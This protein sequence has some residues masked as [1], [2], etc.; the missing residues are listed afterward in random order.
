[1]SQ[2]RPLFIGMD[3]HQET[4]AVAYGAQDPGAAG[5]SLGP[6]GTRQ[7]ASDHLV[8]KRPAQATPL[9]LVYAAGPCGDWR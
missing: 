4:I 3:V 5:T 2:S 7:C 9:G 1:M 8:R 6:I